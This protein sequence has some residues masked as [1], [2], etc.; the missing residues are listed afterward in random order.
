MTTRTKLIL[1]GTGNPNPDPQRQ[2]SALLVLVDSTP[3]VVDFG[4][5]IVRRAAALTPAYG[6]PLAEL[7]IHNLRTAFLTHLHSDHSV[8]YA[9]LILTPWVMGRDAPLAVY[10]PPGIAAM[11]DHI[12]AAYQ[13][14]IRYRVEGLEPTND[15]GWRVA[16][17]TIG[18]GIIYTDELVKVEAF[19]VIHGT[20]P[21]VFGFRFTTPDKVIVISG[22]TAPCASILRYATGADILVHEVYCQRG[23]DRRDPVWQRY[24]AAHHTSTHE[25][26]EIARQT[27]P[28]LL[29]LYHTLFW[30]CTPQEILAEIGATYAGRVVVAADLQ[31]FE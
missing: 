24:H 5:G 20:M 19:P 23:F 9:D 11:T 4:A 10:G 14:D 31:I 17:H 16:A 15:R 28:D 21:D 25:L 13:P 8:G 3:Y 29:V 2:G 7:E 26:A 30:G 18:E 1:L 6:G 22:D 12:L 27:R